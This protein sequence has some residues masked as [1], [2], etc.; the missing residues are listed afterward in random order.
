MTDQ[1]TRASVDK[2]SSQVQVRPV[3]LVDGQ[4]L[5]EYREN[6]RHVLV[7][8]AAEGC[9][10]AIV[11]PPGEESES[12]LCPSVELVGYPVIRLPL[13][14]RQNRNYL[15]ER[16]EKFKPTVLHCLGKRKSRL[17]RIIANELDIPY[18]ITF[19]DIGGRIFKPFIYPGHCGALIASSRTIAEYL[20]KAYP[21]YGLKIRQINLG[22][23]VDKECSCFSRPERIASIIVAQRPDRVDDFAP[24]LNAVRQLSVEGYEF[25]VGIV[26]KGHAEGKV[27]E[28][29]SAL[30]LLQTVTLVGDMQPL[31]SVFAGA[32]IFVQTAC[33]GDFN[34]RLLEAMSVGM[35]VASCREC[36][37]DMLVA[38]RTAVFFD[39]DDEL[40]IYA[41]LK[42]LLSRQEHARE[43][44]AAG[45]E[46]LR[47]F[48]S[49]SRM[50]KAL[51]QT[52]A[53][54]QEQYRQ[55][56]GE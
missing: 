27:H 16:L 7:A 5:R 30:G 22:T 47:R 13:F 6:L 35:V 53:S 18:V 51:V 14:F 50:S 19:N 36:F 40:S 45:Q 17:G 44:A 54:V 42:D 20:K 2:G 43:I 38:D 1:E 52:Y 56:E 49:V 32:D 8:F 33:S 3:L 23:F 12:I 21:R 39:G 11:C 41:C 37:D 46:Y 31:R 28:L 10:S 25:V 29:I 26:G 4:V 9:A 48:Y 24:F 15:L 55:S 34:A